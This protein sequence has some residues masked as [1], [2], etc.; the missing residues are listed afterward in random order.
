M[1]R[2][3]I[4]THGCQMN[5]HDSEKVANLLHHHGYRSAVE[6]DDADLLILNTCSIREKAEHR[7]YSELGLLRSWKAAGTGRVLGVAGC[8]A[9][10]EGDRILRRFRQVDFVFGTHNLRFVPAMVEAARRGLRGLRIEESR[11]LERFDLPE[12]HPEY[13][14]HTPGRAFVTVMEGCDM[15]CSFC[16]VPHTR[17]REISRPA[18]SIVAEVESL[19]RQGVSEVTLLGQTVNA[20]GRHDGRRGRSAEAGTASFAGLLRRLDAVPGIERIRYTSPHPIFFDSDLVRAHAE[21][22]TLCPHVHLPVQS[23][24]DAVLARMRR[25]HG[26][27][28]YRSLVERLRQARPDIALTTDLIVG[29]PGESDADFRDTLSLVDEVGFVDSFSFKYSPRPHTQAAEFEDEVPP[30]VAQARLEE[31]QDLQR[32]LTLAYHRRRVGERAAVMV[33]GPS[34]QGDGQVAGRDVYHRV[35][36]VTAGAEVRPGARIPVWLVEA[37]PHSL[38]GERLIE[39]SAQGPERALKPRAGSADELGRSAVDRAFGPGAATPFG[40][41]HAQGPHSRRRRPALLPGADRGDPR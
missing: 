11:S 30:A 16:V 19:A 4:R 1:P 22:P 9:Q 24:S 37:T 39:N 41:P 33:E 2:F 13:V 27:D 8:V 5:V 14:G 26:A 17:G 40:S 36:N 23:G 12:R 20:Y 38:I 15:F 25:R 6:L 32:S 21:L 31:L 18:D 7:L 10:Q 28:A 3:L 34:R 35:V 29:F